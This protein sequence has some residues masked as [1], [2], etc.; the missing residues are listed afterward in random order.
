MQIYI[1]KIKSQILSLTLVKPTENLLNK[2]FK[3]KNLDL[4]YENLYIKCY[5]FYQ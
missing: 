3:A 4:Y 1:K 5:Y 2:S